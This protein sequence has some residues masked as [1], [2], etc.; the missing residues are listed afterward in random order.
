MLAYAV[1]SDDSFVYSLEIWQHGIW[2]DMR[3]HNT[4]WA[5][6]TERQ[7]SWIYTDSMS[8]KMRNGRTQDVMSNEF[9][10]DK[11]DACQH[12]ER[13]LFGAFQRVNKW[14]AFVCRNKFGRDRSNDAVEAK[15]TTHHHNNN[16]HATSTSNGNIQISQLQSASFL[17]SRQRFNTVG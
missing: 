7:W 1:I 4:V 5:T 6:D 10:V 16:V 3:Q 2:T 15:E 12:R 9:D 13:R 14:R 17:Y 8:Y 11:V